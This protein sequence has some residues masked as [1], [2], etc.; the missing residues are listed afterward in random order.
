VPLERKRSVVNNDVDRLFFYA[1]ENACF[2]C[3]DGVQ[4][5]VVFV[6]SK[7]L[8]ETLPSCIHKKKK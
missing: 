1:E 2:V 8:S 5:S 4:L 6:F 7:D 3:N